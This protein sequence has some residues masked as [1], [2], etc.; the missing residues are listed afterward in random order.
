M[1][2][3]ARRRISYKPRY[4]DWEAYELLPPTLRK[5]LQET[6]TEWSSSWVLRYWKKHGL[7]ATINALKTADVVYMGKGWIP[8][9][10]RRPKLN[11]TF[12]TDRIAPLRTYGVL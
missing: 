4:T 8:A 9:H 3:S 10:G 7:A 11:S 6:V 12:V 5:A 2:N 1:A